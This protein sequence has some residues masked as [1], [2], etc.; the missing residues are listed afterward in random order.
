MCHKTLF[1][2][3]GRQALIYDAQSVF[4]GCILCIPRGMLGIVH[5]DEN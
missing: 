4:C 5:A 2:H 3:A 1:P